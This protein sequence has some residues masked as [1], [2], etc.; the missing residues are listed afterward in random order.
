MYSGKAQ[1]VWV[2]A[3]SAAILLAALATNLRA[4]HT[5]PLMRDFIG[6][7]GHTV[8]FKAELYQPVCRL[9][10]DYHPVSWDLGTNTS[11]PPPFPFA[12]NRVDW[13]K[14]YGGWRDRDW[15]ID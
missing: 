6:L 15:K 4:E 2:A 10:R 8:Q 14:V 11:E 7:N 5:S 13:G 1:P 3:G 9:V 12:K